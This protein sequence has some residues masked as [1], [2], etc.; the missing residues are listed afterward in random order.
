[1]SARCDEDWLV[2]LGRAEWE[3]RYPALEPGR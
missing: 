2:L 1:M 3:L